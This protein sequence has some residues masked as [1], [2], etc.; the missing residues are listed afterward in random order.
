MIAY[1][2]I[3]LLT[4]YLSDTFIQQSVYLKETNVEKCLSVY[5]AYPPIWT[6]SYTDRIG[7]QDKYKVNNPYRFLNNE[8]KYAKIF[9]VTYESP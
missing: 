9:C 8:P 6:T 5:S 2:I 1:I 4:I 7:V 3:C